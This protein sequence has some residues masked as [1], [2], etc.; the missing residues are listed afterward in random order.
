MCRSVRSG[1]L[2]SLVPAVITVSLCLVP[3]SGE[4]T[5]ADSPNPQ[6]PD[7]KPPRTDGYHV[8]YHNATIHTGTGDAP[9]VGGFVAVTAKGKISAVGTAEEFRKLAAAPEREYRDLKG[10]VVIPG[11]VDT[12]SHIGLFGRGGGG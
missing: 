7:P 3:V 1:W 12:H 9:I 6:Q 4:I 5:S 8:V 10:A 11:L 2:P